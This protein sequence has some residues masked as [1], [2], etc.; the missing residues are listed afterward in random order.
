VG[1]TLH[2]YCPRRIPQD[3]FAIKRF[4]K[5]H[6][7]RVAFTLRSRVVDKLCQLLYNRYLLPLKHID[8]LPALP[9]ADFNDTAV[10]PVQAQHLLA[11]LACSEHQRETCV[12]EVGCWTGVTTKLLA[13][14]TARKL[15][16]VDPYFPTG[17][18]PVVL[19]RF[20]TR[21][22]ALQTVTHLRTTS[23]QAALDWKYE[24]ISMV[25]IDAVHDYYN[26]RFDIE[27][28]DRMLVPGGF[29]ALHDT[30]QRCFAGTRRAVFR[31]ARHYDLFAHPD[32]LTIFRK[33]HS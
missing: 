6:P 17:A 7:Y 16:A 30:D 22:A 10:T 25:F 27:A 1:T 15:Y 12:V 9:N 19:E 21:T 2:G 11:A 14:S 33:L 29:L 31:T 32:N 26:V 23:G 20:R 18:I 5:V 13:Q 28:W 8:N 3:P 24:P 4:S